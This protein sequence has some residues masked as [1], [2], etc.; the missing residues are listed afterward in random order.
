MSIASVVCFYAIEDNGHPFESVALIDFLY[1]RNS[2]L[3]EETGT[4]DEDGNIRSGC[5]N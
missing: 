4:E 2:S 3:V 5:D 1:C